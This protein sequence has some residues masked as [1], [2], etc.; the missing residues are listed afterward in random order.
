MSDT[1]EAQKAD[2]KHRSGILAVECC[3]KWGK[4]YLSVEKNW[5]HR[6]SLI[7]LPQNTVILLV[8]IFSTVSTSDNTVQTHIGLFDRAGASAG[9]EPE[10]DL[11]PVLC[12]STAAD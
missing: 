11:A 5:Q 4:R 7:L 12:F 8:N 2:D 3:L 9:S 10:P 1:L 6:P